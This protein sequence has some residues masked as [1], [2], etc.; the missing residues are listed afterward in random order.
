MDRTGKIVGTH[1]GIAGYTIGQRKGLGIALGRPV[2][3]FKIDAEN[4]IL[5]VGDDEDLFRIGFEGKDPLWVSIDAPDGPIRAQVRIRHNHKPRSAVIT[6]SGDGSVQ[7]RFDQPER[8]ITPGQ[9]AVF[10]DRDIVLGSA[11]IDRVFESEPFA[12]TTAPVA[13]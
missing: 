7:V 3:V 12:G 5:F 1:H 10:Y 6:P 8:A 4:N 9:L 13:L 11:W 2:F